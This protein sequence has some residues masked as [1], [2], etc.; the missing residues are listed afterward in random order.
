MGTWMVYFDN[1]PHG[2]FGTI[3]QQIW[4]ALHFPIH[5]AI[6]GL[7]EGAQQVALARYVSIGILKLEKGFVQACFKQHLDGADLTSELSDSIKYF[8]L[9]KKLNSLIFVDDI[10]L[11]LYAVGNAT[12]ICG[13]AVKGAAATDFP[14]E[15]L[16]L[17]VDTVA[18]MYSSLGLSLSLDKDVLELMFESWKLVYRYFWGAFTILITC[19]LVVIVLTR[20]NKTDVFDHVAF[21][22]RGAVIGG[23]ASILALSAS[24]DLMYSIMETPTILPLAVGLLYLIIVLD[25]IGAWVANRRN[26]KSGEPLTGEGHGGH[27]SHGGHGDHGEHAGSVNKDAVSVSSAPVS[28]H[29]SHRSS[30]NPLGTGVMP[31]YGY[32]NASTT[33]YNPAMYMAAP[34]AQPVY[35]HPQPAPH[36]GAFP[37]S[38]AYTGY[39]PVNNHSHGDG[40]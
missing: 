39:M 20:R 6:V 37:T 36:A 25:R 24:K 5:L 21:F 4:S 7:A 15:L 31:S 1:H 33:A 8:K 23:A 28:A 22:G 16:Q 3:K 2:H 17:F 14:D 10:Q 13:A 38:A 27:E 34:P 32:D 11:D 9:E 35:A 26:R 29:P 40:Y 19:F 30:Y 18:G 12:G